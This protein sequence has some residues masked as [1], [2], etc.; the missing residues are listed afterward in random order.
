MKAGILAGLSRTVGR[1]Q[2]AGSFKKTN[3]T[4]GGGILG[5]IS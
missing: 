5:A 1:P 3:A 2:S 4:A